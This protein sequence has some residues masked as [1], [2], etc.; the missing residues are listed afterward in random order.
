MSNDL[1]CFPCNVTKVQ[2]DALRVVF[3]TYI[4]IS[5]SLGIFDNIVFRI[6]NTKKFGTD[7]S[8][9]FSSCTSPW[10]GKRIY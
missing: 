3:V 4:D 2:E 10:Y 5:G 6:L 9:S 8:L 7:T 1:K